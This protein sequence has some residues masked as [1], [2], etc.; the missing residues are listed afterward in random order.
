MPPR[1]CVHGLQPRPALKGEPSTSYVWHLHSPR[2][3]KVYQG[4]AI[5]PTHVAHS[6][7]PKGVSSNGSTLA[8]IRQCLRP[9]SGTSEVSLTHLSEV[10][11]GSATQGCRLPWATWALLRKVG[12]QKAS[13]PVTNDMDVMPRDDHTKLL[14]LGWGTRRRTRAA[15]AKA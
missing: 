10:S 11:H 8:F 14:L 4:R 7:S 1:S 2:V 12:A 15:E 9:V 13:A 5:S 6:F 3:Q